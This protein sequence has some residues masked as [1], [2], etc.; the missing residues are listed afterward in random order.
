MGAR[1]ILQKYEQTGRDS[2][3]TEDNRRA[4]AAGRGVGAGGIK[5]Q[6]SKLAI[7]RIGWLT[8]QLSRNGPLW[9]L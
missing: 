9:K 6:C 5:I 2:R 7:G 4:Q 3:G 8:Y 1:D